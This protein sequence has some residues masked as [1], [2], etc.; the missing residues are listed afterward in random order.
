MTDA[1]QAII[2][3]IGGVLIHVH[4]P[5]VY[6]VIEARL[7]LGAGTLAP[8]LWGSD[9]WRLAEVGA[10]SDDEY[11]RRMAPRLGLST[12]EALD[13]LH[14]DL[15]GDLRLDPDLVALVRRLRARYRT[16]MLSNASDSV[17]SDRWRARYAAHDLF[18]VEIVS[19]RV[20]LAKPD[21]AI[22]RLA[23]QQLGVAPEAA[24]FVDDAPPNVAAAAALGIHAVQFTGYPALVEALRQLGVVVDGENPA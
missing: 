14:A 24:V 19:A 6:R 3:D 4:R 10:I 11:W 2:F 17:G 7:G 16:A 13:E 23:L 20:G 22:Y 8:L 12:P 9:E 5:E 21:A 1:I 18:D 15:F